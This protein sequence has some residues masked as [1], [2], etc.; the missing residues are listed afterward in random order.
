MDNVTAFKKLLQIRNMRVDGMSRQLAALRRR[1]DAIAAELEMAEREH[2]AAAD[3]A[4]AVSPT[5]LLQPGMLISGEQ[6]HASH[7]EA[8]LARAEVA[9]IDERR[10]RVAL[11]HRAGT[12]R[13]EK[14]EEAHSSAIRIVRRTECVLE[15]LEE[16]TFESVEDLER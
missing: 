5:R 6:L 4:D 1:Q 14:M 12:T 16:R 13:V 7:Q 10:Q 2:G 9:G 3:R 11:E 8:A 15:E